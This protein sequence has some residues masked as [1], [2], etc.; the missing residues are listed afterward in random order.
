MFNHNRR[1]QFRVII[2]HQSYTSVEKVF[3][4]CIVQVSSDNDEATRLYN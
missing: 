2:Y 1:I 3:L 4:T